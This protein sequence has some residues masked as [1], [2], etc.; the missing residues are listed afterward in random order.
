MLEGEGS[1]AATPLPPLLEAAG[2]RIEGL[3]LDDGALV[4]KVEADGM[5]VQVRIA[6]PA[7]LLAGGG[8]RLFHDRGLALPVAIARLGDL[9]SVSGGALGEGSAGG[10]TGSETG[11]VDDGARSR[12]GRADLARDRGTALGRR[13]CRGG[14]VAGRLDARPRQAPPRQ[15]PRHAQGITCQ[16]MPLTCA[17]FCRRLAN[18]RAMLKAYRD[19]ASGR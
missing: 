18:A 15:R 4:L 1:A 2:A 17:D 19:I 10:R 3:C 7:P 5:A 13:A 12:S 8:V 14:L 11:E 6:D 16:M 9:W